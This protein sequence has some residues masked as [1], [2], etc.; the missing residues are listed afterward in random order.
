MN[1]P[2]HI[3]RF[4]LPTVRELGLP[5]AGHEVPP[6]QRLTRPSQRSLVAASLIVCPGRAGRG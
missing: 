3:R 4:V 1:T 5:G 6:E 2:A